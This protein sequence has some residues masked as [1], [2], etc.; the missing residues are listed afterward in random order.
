MSLGRVPLMLSMMMVLLT[1]GCSESISAQQSPTE[2]QIQ[3]AAEFLLDVHIREVFLKVPAAIGDGASAADCKDLIRARFD[4]E[5][6]EREA[7]LKDQGSFAEIRLLQL[8]SKSTLLDAYAVASAEDRDSRLRSAFAQAA[9]V[10]AK[11]RLS[12]V[13]NAT[14]NVA[15]ALAQ[16]DIEDAMCGGQERAQAKSQLLVFKDQALVSLLQ[17]DAMRV[18]E[19]LGQ[20]DFGQLIRAEDEVRRRQESI[21]PT[22][23]N[24]AAA[25]RRT[26]ELSKAVDA[27]AVTRSRR[28]V[29][30]AVR[31]FGASR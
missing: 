14:D 5:L 17:S 12:R 2:R 27:G 8:K 15:K 20:V 29:E 10:D 7:S 28:D 31:R 22:L 6:A 21:R 19:I 25:Q 11:Q 23:P 1:L 24:A 13:L 9:T 18:R 30:A 26:A 3:R 16:V 4:L